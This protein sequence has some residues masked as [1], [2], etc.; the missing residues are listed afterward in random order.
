MP[1]SLLFPLTICSVASGT[2]LM[3]VSGNFPFA[4]SDVPSDMSPEP[5]RLVVNNVHDSLSTI[6]S[7]MTARSYTD[8][9]IGPAESKLMTQA[10]CRLAAQDRW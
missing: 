9:V 7:R 1:A 8:L 5:V 4:G 10:P 2:G 3:R 6:A